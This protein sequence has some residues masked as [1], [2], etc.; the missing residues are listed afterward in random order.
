MAAARDH[1]LRVVCASASA[2]EHGTDDPATWPPLRLAAARH[3]EAAAAMV[4]LGV[5]EHRFLGLP[6]GGLAEHPATGLAW[7]A[8]LIETVQ[9]DTILTFG[10]DGMTFHPDH[11][12][13]HQWVTKAW[14]G[15]GRRARLLY[16]TATQERL[17]RAKRLYEQWDVFM[18]DERPTGV[19][20]AELALHVRL[21][22]WRLDRKLAALRAM[23]TQ[24]AGVMA[25]VDPAT[26]AAHVA[27]EAFVEAT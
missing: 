3:W 20:A 10:P 16:A 6:D 14:D 15:D 12:E 22:G 5:D 9:P 7:V 17:R 2:G 4:V 21:D 19:P 26:F 24:T 25:T 18:T 13:V 1:G 27:E 8:E 23:A 11:V